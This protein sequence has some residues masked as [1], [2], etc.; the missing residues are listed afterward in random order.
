M[1]AW[2]ITGNEYGVSFVGYENLLKLIVVMVIW[3][4]ISKKTTELYTVCGQ[5]TW[6][7]NY[8]S[9]NFS[10]LNCTHTAFPHNLMNYSSK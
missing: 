8:I 2:G 1:E 10:E 6:Y 4:W 7:V 5:I 9:V 3:L